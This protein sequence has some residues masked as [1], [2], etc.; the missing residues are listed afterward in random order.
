MQISSSI[1][2]VPQKPQA[3]TKTLIKPYADVWLV[4]EE[5]Y[6][7]TA[8]L[9]ASKGPQLDGTQAVYRFQT[10]ADKAPFT[11]RERILNAVGGGLGG[12]V[13]GAVAGAFV[14]GGLLLAAGIIDVLDMMA[15]GDG[16]S[17]STALVAVPT[18]IGAAIGATVGAKDGYALNG[19]AA[20]QEIAGILKTDG[21]KLSFYPN[22]E[23]QREVDLQA[24][25]NAEEA[26]LSKPETKPQNALWNSLKGAAV[27]AALVP[28]Q[29]IPLLG[30]A[31][32]AM[33]GSR[34]GEAMDKRTE[35]GR[36]LGLFTGAALTA[37]GIGLANAQIVPT[38]KLALLAAG[39]LGIAGAA[40]GHTVFSNMADQPASLQYGQQWW[41]Q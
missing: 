25:Q 11:S 6:S 30:L 24:Y 15:Y 33:V 20:S 13:P 5:S 22:G 26:K 23:L 40:L 21:E 32:P 16:I 2:T 1:K 31:A 14:A 39:G 9:L 12:A 37:A 7:S 28:A 18:V 3:P 29:V 34:V 36:G 38:G 27:G 17:V 41:N 4:G 19:E 35:L 8:D 10:E